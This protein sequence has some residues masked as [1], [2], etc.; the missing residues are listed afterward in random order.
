[1]GIKAERTEA[2]FFVPGVCRVYWRGETRQMWR[3][4][5]FRGLNHSPQRLSA[6]QLGGPDVTGREVSWGVAVGGFSI[7]GCGKTRGLLQETQLFQEVTPKTAQWNQL[8]RI[9]RSI[10][11]KVSWRDQF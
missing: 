2:V 9:Q 4:V 5:S 3:G 10:G 6:E 1:M 8:I 11:G 7:T